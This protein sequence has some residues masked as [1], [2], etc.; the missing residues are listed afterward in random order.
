MESQKS[1]KL[2][3][4]SQKKYKNLKLAKIRLHSTR[5][6]QKRCYDVTLSRQEGS[7]IYDAPPGE[8][9][10]LDLPGRWFVYLFCL[11]GVLRRFQHCTGHITTGSW[12]GRG[13]QYIEFARVVYCKLP[14]NGKQLP[15]FPLEPVRGS[16]PGLRGGRPECYHSASV[17]PPRPVETQD[18]F[19]CPTRQNLNLHMHRMIS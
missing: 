16:N 5:A 17:A 4:F 11:F 14:T 9:T 12:K 6:K 18:G 1:H 3:I 7:N 2:A 8:C 10:V 19:F 15:A 13:N